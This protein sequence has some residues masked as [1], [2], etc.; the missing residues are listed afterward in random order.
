MRLGL[1]ADQLRALR[2][3]IRYLPLDL[4]VRIA[5]S[6]SFACL[7]AFRLTSKWLGYKTISSAFLCRYIDMFLH[8]RR[9]ADI[10]T[11]DRSGGVAFLMQLM[12]V[13]ELGGTWERWVPVFHFAKS[14]SAVC[15][16]YGEQTALPIQLSVLDLVH[17]RTKA[18]FLGRPEPIRQLFL[19]GHRLCSDWIAHGLWFD[20]CGRLMLGIH[21]LTI[22]VR[23]CVR[24]SLRFGHRIQNVYNHRDSTSVCQHGP[25]VAGC[26]QD[27]VMDRFDKPVSERVSEH[28]VWPGTVAHARMEAIAAEATP[29]SCRVVESTRFEDRCRMI[30][31]CGDKPGDPFAAFIYISRWSYDNTAS[32]ELKSTEEPALPEWKFPATVALALRIVGWRDLKLLL[33]NLELPGTPP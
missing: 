30:V 19:F 1:S 22:G 25:R 16:L 20:H 18:F 33:P 17:V 2:G 9:I 13:L 14:C 29:W 23:E 28:L 6:F 10:I 27:I 4:L 32:V 8:K 26:L 5:S 12:C 31:L 24:V 15:D 7:T 21:P 3:H 11:F